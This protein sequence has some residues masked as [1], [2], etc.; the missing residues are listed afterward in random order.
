MTEEQPFQKANH[1]YSIQLMK[2]DSE[3]GVYEVRITG[4]DA[5]DISLLKLLR[6]KTHETM[7]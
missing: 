1:N 6:H 2:K 7:C 4:D 5:N 3:C